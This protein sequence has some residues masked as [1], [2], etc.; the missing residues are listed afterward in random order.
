MVKYYY[1]PELHNPLSV[2]QGDAGKGRNTQF[3]TR[4]FN[5]RYDVL[6]MPVGVWL[7]YPTNI[8]MRSTQNSWGGFLDTQSHVRMANT[9]ELALLEVI[10]LKDNYGID[11]SI[12]PFTVTVEVGTLA[13]IN[14][15]QLGDVVND[16]VYSQGDVLRWDEGKP[17]LLTL[18]GTI[19]ATAGDVIYQRKNDVKG[20]VLVDVSN[21]NQVTLVNVRG[22]FS[23]L[24]VDQSLLEIQDATTNAIIDLRPIKPT[25]AVAQTNYNGFGSQDY[26]SF[27][28]SKPSSFG[29]TAPTIAFAGDMWFNT[30]DGEGDLMVYNGDAWIECVPRIHKDTGGGVDM[31]AFANVATSGDYNDLF[32]LPSAASG[33]S[34]SNADSVHSTGYLGNQSG[35]A[36][37]DPV[38]VPSGHTIVLF[39]TQPKFTEAAEDFVAIYETG[40]T[41][42]EYAKGVQTVKWKNT[43]ATTKDV[44]VFLSETQNFGSQGIYIIYTNVVADAA[45]IISSL[46]TVAS[47]GDYNDLINKPS[48][49]STSALQA[50]AATTKEY[51][52]AATS[53]GRYLIPTSQF[54]SG[55]ARRP[56][57]ME[58]YIRATAVNGGYAVGDMIRSENIQYRAGSSRFWINIGFDLDAGVN[59]NVGNGS[60]GT[61][62]NSTNTTEYG[63]SFSEWEIVIYLTWF[64]GTDA[65][66]TAPTTGTV[67]QL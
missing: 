39:S 58:V 5:T 41:S 26:A 66:Y 53:S 55:I 38:A 3:G 61:I 49:L 14:T 12:M 63:A 7:I 8:T 2:F 19:S 56:D 57:D 67:S 64:G 46:A 50:L 4:L 32:N 43:S 54:P 29:N 13:G 27:Y 16:Q 47:T 33:G 30:A 40:G 11:A 20:T 25:A 21:S 34:T 37:L 9:K 59:F 62:L 36:I 10:D 51:V 15:T 44:R 1:Q 23:T 28:G 45:S 31:S 48:A 52:Q 35:A 22:I 42:T 60:Y 6:T 65:Q 18:S 24:D 17:V